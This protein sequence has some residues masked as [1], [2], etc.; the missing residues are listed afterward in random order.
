MTLHFNKSAVSIKKKGETSDAD[1]FP[2]LFWE[3]YFFFSTLIKN[4]KANNAPQA[5]I[6]T[7]IKDG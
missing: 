6:T 1:I 5:A 4:I 3:I 2:F 7:P